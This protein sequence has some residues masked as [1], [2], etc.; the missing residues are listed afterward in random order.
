MEPLH[1]NFPP[2]KN[3]K[4][5]KKILSY[6][7]QQLQMNVS[8]QWHRNM[9][10][11][12]PTFPKRTSSVFFAMKWNCQSK[13][14]RCFFFAL[15]W[16][17]N[18]LSKTKTIVSFIASSEPTESLYMNRFSVWMLFGINEKLIWQFLNQKLAFETTMEPYL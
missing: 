6:C 14:K 18:A 7:L 17:C 9:S 3:I 11:V 13:T 12:S 1:K 4:L 10:S 15:T 2:F 16:N 8:M 5:E